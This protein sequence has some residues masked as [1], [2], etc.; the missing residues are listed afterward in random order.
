MNAYIL[1]YVLT[2]RTEVMGDKPVSVSHF[3]VN[4]LDYAKLKILHL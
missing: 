4:F 2:G 1:I 3:E